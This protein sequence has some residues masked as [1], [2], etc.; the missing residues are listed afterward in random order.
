MPDQKAEPKRPDPEALLREVA[1]ETR[2]HLKVF[3]GAAPGVGKT[4]EMLL[5]AAAQRRAGVDVVIGLI[6]TH[7]RVETEALVHGFEIVRL[8]QLDYNGR[9]LREMDLDAVLARKPALVLV[10][11]LAHTN[12]PGSRHPK[13]YQ[14]VEDL[15]AAGIDVYTAVNIQHLESLNDVVQQITRIKV[16]ETVPDAFLDHA[17]EIEVI[18]LTPADLIQRLKEGKVYVPGTAERA[19]THYFSAGNLTALRELALRRTAQRVDQQLLTHMQAHAIS[20]PW[21]AGDRI[22]VV[23]NEHPKA[24]A[25]VR[26]ARRMAERLRAPWTALYVETPRSLRLNEAARDRIAEALRM[27]ERLGG[28]AVTMPGRELAGEILDYAAKNNFSHI[29]I[30]RSRRSRLHELIFG[31][32]T[33]EIV[34]R[35]GNVA[36][37]VVTGDEKGAPAAKTVDT[38]PAAAP[39]DVRPYLITAAVVAVA[40]GCGEVLAR[41]LNVQNVALVFLT[42]VLVSAVAFGLS[43]ALFASLLSVLA[44]NLFFLPPYFSITISD[45]ENVVALFFFLVVALVASNLTA[46]VRAQALVARQ[47]ARTTEDLYLF[48]RKLAGIA[49]MDDLLWAISSQVASMLKVR[50]VL[51]LPENGS[52]ELKTAWPP[53]D[54]AEEAD[55]AAAKWSWESSRPAGRGADTMPGARRLF[56]PMRTGRGSVAVIGIDSDK[57]GPLLTPDERRLLDALSDQAALAIERINLSK[58]FDKAQRAAER[59][60]LQ[61][62]LLTSISHDLRTPLASILGAADGLAGLPD[63]T[64]DDR[65]ALLSTIQEE[66]ERLNRFI[67]NLLDM[68]K[69]ESGAVTPNM[70]LVDVSEVV[71]STLRRAERILAGHRVETALDPG[72]PM[73][74][75]DPVLFEQVL[76]NLLDNAAKYAPAGTII[77]MEGRRAGNLVSLRILDEGPGIPQADLEHVFDKFYRVRKADSQRAGT[78]LGLAICRGFVEAMGGTIEAGNRADRPGAVFTITLPAQAEATA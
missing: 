54:V 60:R 2:G 21:S 77:S 35:A 14:D 73:V 1:T 70:G 24:A 75:I 55:L 71:G 38:R 74:R 9:H 11:E 16:R 45:P 31:S 58:D 26:Y 50:V 7:G 4:Y 49:S 78:G 44:F 40:L 56:L 32:I 69:L 51:F 23:V 67:A 33:S 27:T 63:L 34:R 28:E 15:L 3:L 52:L 29:V 59:D 30:G 20:G 8:R 6:E 62:A 12:A 57:Q 43:A 37:H 18:D 66:A 68:T 25:L 46:S 53:E 39:F 17:D 48:S 19:L 47:R 65:K 36:V 13:R 22:L 61:A 72:L 10:D 76:F 41:F 5:S 42:A 64:V